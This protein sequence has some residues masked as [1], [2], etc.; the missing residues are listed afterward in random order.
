VK[1]TD[2]ETAQRMAY[3]AALQDALTQ[4]RRN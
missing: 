4:L 1:I 2:M 3:N